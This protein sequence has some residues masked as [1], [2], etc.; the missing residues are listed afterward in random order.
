MTTWVCRTCLS[1]S[2]CLPL[3][4]VNA[5]Q[6][7]EFTW[8]GNHEA[9][10]D[11]SVGLKGA[12]MN[13]GRAGHD[14]STNSAVVL[15]YQFSKLLG[16]P[17]SSGLELEISNAFDEGDILSDG[18]F[19]A[20]GE[21]SS[22]TLGLYFTYRSPGTVYFLGKV[23]ALKTDVTT[24]IGTSADFKEQDTSFSYGGG[25]GLNLGR[26]GNFNVEL[27]FV[28]SSGDNDINMITLGGHYRFE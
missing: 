1:V 13:T 7:E 4:L 19:G 10:G 8:F 20:P 24:T 15:G 2:L 28:G 14:D 26:T 5:T 17:G 12:S 23:G 16:V 3:L 22:N 6:A 9:D 25:L 21:W 11:W 18:Q 27:E